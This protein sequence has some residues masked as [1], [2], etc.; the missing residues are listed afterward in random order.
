MSSALPLRTHYSSVDL[1]R[2]AKKTKDKNQR[3]RLLCILA[4]LD[5]M[6]RTDAVRIGMMDHQTPRDGV[7]RFNEQ[8]PC[9]LF[10]VHAGGIEPRFSAEKLREL[11]AVVDFHE[12]LTRD[13]H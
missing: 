1:R 10:S 12:E 6:N 2:L 7:H 9:G 3:R 13:F 11:A 5:G 4:V 8:G